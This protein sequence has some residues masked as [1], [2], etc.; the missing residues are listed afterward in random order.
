MNCLSSAPSV[1]HVPYFYK[2]T[3]VLHTDSSLINRAELRTR[4]IMEIIT[5]GICSVHVNVTI[6]TM[7][8]VRLQQ[9]LLQYVL[10]YVS[11]VY[12]CVKAHTEQTRWCIHDCVLWVVFRLFTLFCYI[13]STKNYPVWYPWFWYNFVFLSAIPVVP[14]GVLFLYCIWVPAVSYIL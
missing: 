9:C 6:F 2:R 3:S 11:Y 5:V 14:H 12:Y 10:R 1:T 8:V 7:Y 13:F 4:N